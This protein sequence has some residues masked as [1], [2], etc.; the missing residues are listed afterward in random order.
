P[1]LN[2][3]GRSERCCA[4]ARARLASAMTKTGFM[5]YEK[6]TGPSPARQA[7]DGC[8]ASLVPSL[9][10]MQSLGV[11]G[12]SFDDLHAPDRLASLYERFC[13]QVNADDP[14]FWR[15]WDAYRREPDAARSPL[16]FSNLLIGMAPHVSRFLKRLFDVDASA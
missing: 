10:P 11:A 1:I 14:A 13:E 9:D 6:R 2:G 8:P 4:G 15:E 7:F 5:R 16:A 12:Y 3:T